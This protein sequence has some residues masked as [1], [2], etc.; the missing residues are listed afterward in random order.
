MTASTMAPEANRKKKIITTAASALIWL[1]AWQ[2]S[3]V[4]I[5]QELFLASPLSVLKSLSGLLQKAEFY[6]TVG[7]SLLRILT[8]FFAAAVFGSVLSV[9]AYKLP[10]FETFFS[11]FM[12][13][14]KA[15]PVASFVVLALLAVGSK[16]LA[17]LISFLMVFPVFYT[18]LLSGMKSVDKERF[19]AAEVFGM[20]R[21]DRFR[22][23]Y[24]PYV[25]PH[26]KSA[27]QVGMGLSWKAGISAEV[28]GI[29][30]GSIGGK[31]YEAKLFL[32]TAELLAYTLVVVLLSLLLEKLLALLI[33]AMEKILTK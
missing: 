16:N 21:R 24:L 14:V 8:G 28:I 31:L 29:T 1:A 5:G 30:S 33:C 12:G 13:A 11:P 10:F 32:E 2:L 7:Y 9:I 22:F 25:A 4:L 6:N 17:A 3:A 18:S 20:L 15:A 26:L 19:E 23:I 27:C